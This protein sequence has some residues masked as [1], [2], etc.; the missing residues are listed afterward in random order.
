MIKLYI[1]R[2][3]GPLFKLYFKLNLLTLFAALLIFIRNAR[4]LAGASDDGSGM[5]PIMVLLTSLM[6]AAVLMLSVSI[7][8]AKALN[9]IEDFSELKW[10]TIDFHPALLI[11]L[12]SVLFCL[13]LS[14]PYFFFL[15]I[16]LPGMVVLHILWLDARKAAK[17]KLRLQSKEATEEISMT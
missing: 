5:L 14:I 3:A 11:G 4:D 1:Y 6:V 2:I 10:R 16:L 12:G 13:C 17:L 15:A 8:I 7:L 9:R